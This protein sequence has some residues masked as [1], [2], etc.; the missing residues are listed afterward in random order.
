MVRNLMSMMLSFSLVACTQ[1]P[2]DNNAINTADDANAIAGNAAGANTMEQASEESPDALVP[3]TEFH[4]V[5]EIP[6]GIGESIDAT[7][8]AGVKRNPDRT[9]FVEVTKPDGMKRILFFQGTNASG[10]DSSE[11]DGSSSYRFLWH[12]EDDW[13]VIRYG[14][15]RY[16]IPDALIIGG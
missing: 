15:E 5:A 11:A 8:K 14:P 9:S 16:R 4:A 1:D 13:T 10:A 3:G 6:C 7:C 12:R 2:A